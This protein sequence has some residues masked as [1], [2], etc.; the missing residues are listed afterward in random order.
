MSDL[1]IPLTLGARLSWDHKST[2]P[3]I[4]RL[5]SEAKQLQWDESDIEWGRHHP[6]VRVDQTSFGRDAFDAS[7]L[8]RYGETLWR[9]FRTEQQAWMVS[10]FLHGEQSALVVSARLA[11]V[12]PDTDSKGYAASQ[13]AEEARHVAVFGRYAAERL[14]HSYPVFPSFEGL[15]GQILSD[16][17]WDILALGMHVMIESLA[18]GAFRLASTTFDDPLI[19]HITH[20]TSRDEARHVSFG[21][22]LLDDVYGRLSEAELRYREEFV[23]EA[24]DLLSRRYLLTDIWERLGVNADEGIEFARSNPMMKAYRCTIFGRVRRT[25]SAVGLMT[26][27][28]ERQFDQLGL[29]K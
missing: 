4:A 17:R 27:R 3:G 10:Q 12:L 19:R 16:S 7:T 25:L 22:L 1:T 20:L 23:M 21:V 6:P 9:A 2:H 11:E 29:T 5:Y 18:L 14:S 28:I 8:G 13:A 15:V 24:A 26:Q